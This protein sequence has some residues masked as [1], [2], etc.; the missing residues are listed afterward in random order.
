MRF[1]STACFMLMAE[2]YYGQ[3]NTK[4]IVIE[5]KNN[6]VAVVSFLDKNKENIFLKKSFFICIPFF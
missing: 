5:L 2:I 3:H 1:F 6:N 4:T